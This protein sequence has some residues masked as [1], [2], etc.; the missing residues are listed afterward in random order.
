[1]QLGEVPLPEP[2]AGEV[3]VRHGAIGVNFIDVYFRTGTY[4]HALPFTNGQEGAGIVDAVGAGVSDVAV[5]DRVAYCNVLGAY[6]E[7]NIVPA[8]GTVPIPNDVS[9]ADACAAL[10]QGM[11]AHYL[12]HD[13][14]SLQPGDIALVH[15]A[16]GGVGNLLVQMA[17]LRGATVIATAGGPEK[18]ALAAAEG[19]DHVIDYN[20][21][22][23][24]VATERAVGKNAVSVVY[25]A[26]GKTTWERSL[27]VLRPRGLL[28]IY[29]A[30]SGPVP[31]IDP[32]ALMRGGSLYI[33]RPTLVSYRLTRE[34]LLGRAADV[35]GMIAGG[36]LKVRIGKT[37]PLAEASQA[38][39]DLESRA[40]VGKLLLAPLSS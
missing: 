18:C 1:M 12:S 4:P 39:R 31:P 35:Y 27:S 3:R 6:A 36:R 10:L 7:A 23:F 32:L 17:K 26:V 30:S 16:A 29:G 25:D 11:T 34:E 2:G 14:W 5:G 9:D 22:D 33:T 20:A 21:E 15:A 28:A 8:A 19:A 24:A 37:Y 38:H 13:T 40:T